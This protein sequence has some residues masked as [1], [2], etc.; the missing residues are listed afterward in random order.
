MAKQEFTGIDFDSIDPKDIIRK[1]QRIYL[2]Q[3]AEKWQE[4]KAL[5]QEYK[6]NHSQIEEIKSRNSDVSFSIQN[7]LDWIQSETERIDSL[8]YENALGEFGDGK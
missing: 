4:I 1:A 5:E 8:L 7:K 3:R 2:L 6:R